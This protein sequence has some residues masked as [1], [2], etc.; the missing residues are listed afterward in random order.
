MPPQIEGKSR[1]CPRLLQ[2]PWGQH[3]L[4]RFL[5]LTSC[6][7]WRLN[8]S[9][10]ILPWWIRAEE[11]VACSFPQN[12]AILKNE[13]NGRFRDHTGDFCP[14]FCTCDVF[15]Y[16]MVEGGIFV[17]LLFVPLHVHGPPTASSPVSHVTHLQEHLPLLQELSLTRSRAMSIMRLCVRNFVRWWRKACKQIITIQLDMCCESS[18]HRTDKKATGYLEDL[19]SGLPE[20]RPFELSLD[21]DTSA[22]LSQGEG[23]GSLWAK[24]GPYGKAQE[25]GWE[26]GVTSGLWGWVNSGARI[27]KTSYVMPMSLDLSL[28][29]L[30]TEQMIL[31]RKVT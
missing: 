26:L 13:H 15:L 27:Q 12:K 10:T 20:S 31:I 17:P 5:L 28:T 6:T 25:C 14:D 19:G 4:G 2:M 29:A 22:K 3:L 1:F 16:W 8:L 11:R 9:T 23:E 30:G 24:E 7:C 21:E 18:W